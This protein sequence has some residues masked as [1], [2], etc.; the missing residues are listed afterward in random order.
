MKGWK[1]FEVP[2]SDPEF[3]VYKFSTVLGYTID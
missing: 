2:L 3:F 1:A